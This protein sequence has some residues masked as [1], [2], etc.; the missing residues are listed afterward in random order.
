MSS[1]KFGEPINRYGFFLSVDTA[2]LDQAIGCIPVIVQPVDIPENTTKID[3]MFPDHVISF[4][5]PLKQNKKWALTMRDAISSTFLKKATGKEKCWRCHLYITS[6][7]QLL[8]CPIKRVPIEE[9]QPSY[10]SI[11]QKKDISPIS[12]P[13]NQMLEKEV[14]FC[15]YTKGFFC[16][17][18]CVMGYIEDNRDKPEY[19]ESIQFLATMYKESGFVGQINS[20]PP[21]TV[22]IEYGGFL[23]ESEYRTKYHTDSYEKSGNDYVRMIPVGELLKF[24]SK[25]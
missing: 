24:S 4:L 13:I 3:R 19:R 22:L 11:A 14:E 21:F 8:G 1:R 12:N 16:D 17:W 6:G 15:Y 9:K 20:S 25:F 5:D 2:A 23:S 10:F 18:S 7:A